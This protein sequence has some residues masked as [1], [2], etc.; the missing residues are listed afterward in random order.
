MY[1]KFV[2]Q[3]TT[4]DSQRATE[5]VK[6]LCEFLCDLC[7]TLCNLY[8]VSIN[9]VITPDIVFFRSSFFGLIYSISTN[10]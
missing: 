4:E 2:T 8:F 3:R 10:F 7:A 6:K 9:G 1:L 5:K